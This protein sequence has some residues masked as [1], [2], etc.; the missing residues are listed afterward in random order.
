MRKVNILILLCLAIATTSQAQIF[1]DYVRAADGY[2]AK[3]DYFSA[4]QY[5]EKYLGIA[6]GKPAVTASFN[7]Y[8]LQ[9]KSKKGS[10]TS[11]TLSTKEQAVYNI[12]E[13]Y[14]LLNYPAKA[15]PAYKEV[16]EKSSD[17]FPLAHLQYAAVLRSLQKYEDASAQLQRFLQNYTTEDQNREAAVQ[18]MAS[19]TFIQQQ[20]A[21]NI[22]LFKVNKIGNADISQGANYASAFNNNKI[23]FTSTRYD[24]VAKTNNANNIYQATYSFG[25]LKNVAKISPVANANE[26]QGTATISADGN[27]MYFTKWVAKNGNKNAAIYT[28]TYSNGMWSIPTMVEGLNVEGSST[29]QPYLAGTKLYFSSN[30]PEGLGGY[31]LYEA[32]IEGAKATKVTNLG[33]IVNTKGDEQAP[34]YHEGS[35]QLIFASNGKVGM[36]GYDLYSHVLTT[37]AV[38]NLGHPI[39]SVKDDIYFSSISNT[40]HVLDNAVI[41]TDRAADCCLELFAVSKERLPKQISGLVK[42]CDDQSPIANATVSF[43]DAN[44]N[45]ITTQTTDAIGRYQ[46]TLDEYQPMS[47]TASLKGLEDG[48][49]TVALPVGDPA[50]LLN[51]DI[52]LTRTFPPPPG[53]P[54]VLN[55]IYFEYD[56]ADLLEE[57][58]ATLDVLVK[59][60]QDHP[61]VSIEIGGHTDSNGED[62]YNERLSQRRAQS[63][64]KY[65]VSKGVDAKR[66]VA[67]GY[68][69]TTPVA[70]NTNEDGSDNPD[71]RAK[72]RRT[73]FKVIAQK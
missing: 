73:E 69:E 26:Q 70:E 68:G 20:L 9:S 46:F 62:K 18:A 51:A 31:D 17:K 32:D 61:E 2:Y 72:N 10:G 67:K 38:E 59:N 36:G 40:K 37:D 47:G 65:L 56:K 25:E 60:M 35:K 7:P 63:V 30:R 48:K 58:N 29:Q 49:I 53:E 43:V 1:A 66:L 44:N 8:T 28:A 54:I 52:C 55:N 11:S 3:G 15:E 50:S 24:S 64:V 39:N 57:S 34:F 12:A 6:K 14:R 4:A 5:Y 22:D 27:T 45:V 21:K 16:V 42:S 19:L 41:S 33:G 71:G 23:Y 13:C